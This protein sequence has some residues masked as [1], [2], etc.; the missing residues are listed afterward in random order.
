M[1]A[2]GS[3]GVG[4]GG[5]GVGVEDGVDDVQ[6]AVSEEEV[7]LD[8]AGLVDEEGVVDEGDG[9]VAALQG[10]EDA[11]VVDAAVLH[12]LTVGEVGGVE[13]GG[14]GGHDVVFEKGGEVL[15]R[16]GG[17]GAGDGAE[18]FIVGRE[19]GEILGGFRVIG[20]DGRAGE[21][22]AREGA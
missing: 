16:E 5:G 1:A 10:G 12:D 21:E 6:Y 20:E 4:G 22:G 8:D 14:V 13:D 9:E 15:H 11:G 3:V 17:E 19:D 7:L 2:H 18:G